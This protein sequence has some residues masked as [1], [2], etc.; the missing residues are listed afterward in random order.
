[1]GGFWLWA[2]PEVWKKFIRFSGLPIEKSGINTDTYT[3]L[4]TSILKNEKIINC[5]SCK[6][7]RCLWLGIFFHYHNRYHYYSK[8][9][10]HQNFYA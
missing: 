3:H 1:M 2:F 6:C 10:H 7:F 5:I 9:R 4:I 8:N